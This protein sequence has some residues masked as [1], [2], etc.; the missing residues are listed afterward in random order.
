MALATLRSNA[1]ASL[2]GIE[3]TKEWKNK[4]EGNDEYNCDFRVL[5]SSVLGAYSQYYAGSMSELGLIVPLSDGTDSVSEEKG[6][7][8]ASL[9]HEVI[10]RTPYIQK[11]LFGKLK[12]PKDV[13]DKSSEYLSLDALNENFARNERDALVDIM[14]GK[15]E[16]PTEGTLRRRQTLILILNTISQCQRHSIEIR[17]EEAT[18]PFD[19]RLVFQPY[20]YG[21]LRGDGKRL[22]IYEYPENLS[23]C[24]ALWR[25]FCLHQYF[26]QALEIILCCVLELIGTEP[27][28]LTLDEV[29]SQLVTSQFRKRLKA[30]IGKTCDS[31]K[32][33]MNG[34]QIESVP[35][36]VFCSEWR[37]SAGIGN[38]LSEE[39]ILS[40]D[41]A[42]PGVMAAEAIVILVVLYAKWRAA[43]DDKGIKVIAEHAGN[44]IWA[45]TF[46]HEMDG[47]LGAADWNALLK[48]LVRDHIIRRHDQTMYIK[49]RLD[50]CWLRQNEGRLIK[51]QDYEPRW[52]S[53]RHRSALSILSDLGLLNIDQ[54]NIVTIARE[55]RKLLKEAAGLG[56]V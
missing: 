38:A 16:N 17:T 46:L 49:R 24:L 22:F 4:C 30:L 18:N 28:G 29:I 48:T 36:R 54:Y 44:E 50:S 15:E 10:L 1:E 37:K 12:I 6:R 42:E 52:R 39:A 2:A 45:W 47:W 5:P 35:N 55:G 33:L 41:R 19:S 32:K 53:S 13:L 40:G 11:R 21:K 3:A 23:E 51:E 20:Y 34:L 27:Q 14:F 31:P 43:S 26:I 25:Q 7:L 9:H 56:F 8:L